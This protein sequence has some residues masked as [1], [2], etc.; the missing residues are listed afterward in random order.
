MKV[1][2][3]VRLYTDMSESL[4][5]RLDH[6]I[7]RTL[8]FDTLFTAE[9]Q[10]SAKERLLLAAAARTLEVAV[11]EKVPLRQHI[12]TLSRHTLRLL[13]LLLTDTSVFE[14]AGRPPRPKQ[15][16]NIS[17]R[18]AFGMIYMSA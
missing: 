2:E 4:E 9:Q 10:R 1:T 14:R 5:E 8:K 18:Y 3:S 13:A 6:D 11:E 7:A 15:Y 17:G 12:L 16:Y